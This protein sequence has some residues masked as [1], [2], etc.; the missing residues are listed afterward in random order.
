MKKSV[1][2]K[3]DNSEEAKKTGLK[4]LKK[5]TGKEIDAGML[6][7]E[8]IEEKRG[9]LGL[10][11]GDRKY[12]VSINEKL[13]KREADF[14]DVTMET[15][16]VDGRYKIKIVDEGV[17]LKVISPEGK[18]REVRYLEVKEGIEKKGIVEVDWQQ[19]K[20]LINESQDEWGVIAPRKPELDRD[21]EVQIELSKD[22]LKAFI[23]YKPAYGGKELTA[24]DLRRLLGENGIVHGIKNDQ[25]EDLIEERKETKSVLIAEGSPPE[26]G[27]DAE[28]VYHF[29]Q[30][31]ES[32]GT[33]RED[34]SIDFYNLGLINNVQPGEVLVVK[35]DPV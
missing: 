24:A 1:M 3:A 11:K 22:K 14:L 13:S 16:K 30:N 35:K 23:S 29:E 31:K 4:E 28:L 2:I 34:G 33:R 19:V 9:F 27:K 25:L 21:A 17:F 32:V 12:R 8:L 10:K 6:L 26:E 18:G 15:I 5:V 20:E 7:V